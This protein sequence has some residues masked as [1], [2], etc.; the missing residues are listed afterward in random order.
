MAK[1]IVT[2]SDQINDVEIS[3]FRLMSEKEVESFESLAESIRWSFYFQLAN[4]VELEFAD[5]NDLLSKL[6]FKE[7]SAEEFKALKKVFSEGFGTFIDEEFL[8]QQIEEEEDEILDEEEDGYYDQEDG[9]DDEDD[10]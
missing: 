4:D 10:F 8:E 9:F 5:G 3:G 1:Y 6:D 2:F 7:V